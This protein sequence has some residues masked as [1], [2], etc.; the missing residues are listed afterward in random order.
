MQ[1]KAIFQTFEIYDSL[2]DSEL[3]SM[4]TK[5]EREMVEANQKINELLNR[6]EEAKK[7]FENKMIKEHKETIDKISLKL[8]E[9]NENI[10][11]ISQYRDEKKKV[12]KKLK[13]ERVE[14]NKYHSSLLNKLCELKKETDDAKIEKNKIEESIASCSV[15]KC[16]INKELGRIEK[17]AQRRIQRHTT[18][19]KKHSN[20]QTYT[21]NNAYIMGPQMMP[22]PPPTPYENYGNRLPFN[23]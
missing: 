22:R 11:K 3:V 20:W 1:Y 7:E 16:E 17:K 8:K 21:S 4:K 5:H 10:G 14:K 2:C 19:K 12:L 23:V 18:R 13:E 15:T 6:V 9:I